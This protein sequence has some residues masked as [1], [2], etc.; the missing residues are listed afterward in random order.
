MK[1]ISFLLRCF[2][3]TVIIVMP[4]SCVALF[5]LTEDI[6]FFIPLVLS[7]TAVVIA[8]ELDKKGDSR[9]LHWFTRSL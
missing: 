5:G 8:V 4:V 9:L 1:Y 7:F 2:I 6:A 3:A